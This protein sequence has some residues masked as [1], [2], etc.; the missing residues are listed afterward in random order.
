[1]FDWWF[2]TYQILKTV[3]FAETEAQCSIKHKIL[4]NSR[5]I[6]AKTRFLVE[7]HENE[8]GAWRQ[9]LNWLNCHGSTIKFA[10]FSEFP[11]SNENLS[12]VFQTFRLLEQRVAY[13]PN[14]PNL[15]NLPFS[16]FDSQSDTNS[17]SSKST[18]FRIGSNQTHPCIYSHRNMSLSLC[19]NL[20]MMCCFK[21]H[22]RWCYWLDVRI[23]H[24][25]ISD[26]RVIFR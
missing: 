3:D 1:M 14:L 2:Q 23:N 5:F 4:Q 7:I 9:R 19:I 6:L 24:L 20:A 8:S 22:C 13:L 12:K 10:L 18:V 17:E 26:P 16:E 11:K 15:P 21:V 25:Q